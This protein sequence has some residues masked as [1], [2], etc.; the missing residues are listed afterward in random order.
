MVTPLASILIWASKP[1]GPTLSVM[2]F[3]IHLDLG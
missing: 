2:L 3:L 1:P